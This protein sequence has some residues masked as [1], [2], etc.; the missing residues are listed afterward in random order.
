MVG[1]RQAPE[2]R[3]WPAGTDFSARRKRKESRRLRRQ[4]LGAARRP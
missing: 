4:D 1:W 2:D 3:L